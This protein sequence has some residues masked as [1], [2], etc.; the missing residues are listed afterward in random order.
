MQFLGKSAEETVLTDENNVC[1]IDLSGISFEVLSLVVSL[2]SRLM[3]NFMYHSKKADENGQIHNPILMVY[4]EAHNYIPQS[5]SVKFRAVKESIERIS[6][7]GRKYGICSMIVSQRPSE[8]SETI[9]SQCNSFMVMRLTNPTDQSYVRRLLPD[10]IGSITDNLS[11]LE[12]QEVLLLGSAIPIP[13][14]VKVNKIA[15]HILPRSTDIDFMEKWR[16]DRRD[17]NYMENVI[18]LMTPPK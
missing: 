6:K 17:L 16:G 4:E 8:I 15:E 18:N 14:I 11:G 2:I 9:F 3:F 13:T 7:E 5:N 1:I 12:S 10:S